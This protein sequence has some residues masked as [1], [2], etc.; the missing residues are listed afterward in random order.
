MGGS[1]RDSGGGELQFPVVSIM[2]EENRHLNGK[3]Q[4]SDVMLLRVPAL[5]GLVVGTS[6]A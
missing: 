3:T 6:A 5:V 2:K 4:L 1:G